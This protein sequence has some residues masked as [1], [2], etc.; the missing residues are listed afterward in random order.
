M[1]KLQAIKAVFGANATR[2]KPVPK[3]AAVART[4]VVGAIRWDAYFSQPGEAAY[5]DPNFG[6]VTRTT[7]IDM[8][9][10]KWCAFRTLACLR[11][12]GWVGGVGWRWK[13]A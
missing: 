2:S 8:S 6:I 13:G 1:A 7:T 3:P 11:G 12:D 5:E 10:K 4:P 9:P